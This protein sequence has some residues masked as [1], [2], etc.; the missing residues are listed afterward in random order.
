MRLAGAEG[1][2]SDGAEGNIPALATFT[3][4][5]ATERESPSHTPPG[6]ALSCPITHLKRQMVF[7]SGTLGLAFRRGMKR[8]LLHPVVWR[9]RQ[10]CSPAFPGPCPQGPLAP[11]NIQAQPWPSHSRIRETWANCLTFLDLSCLFPAK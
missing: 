6:L 10:P 5:P 11:R 7:R 2:R 1:R 9:Q 3:A 4:A 8:L